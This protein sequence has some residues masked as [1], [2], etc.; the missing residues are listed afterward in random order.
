MSL[1]DGFKI[2]LNPAFLIEKAFTLWGGGGGGGGD[3][4]QTS[5]STNLPEYAKPYYQELLKQT[6]KAVFQ[7]DAAGN[8]TGVKPYTPYTGER[9]AGFTPEQQAIQQQV[10][11][12]GTPEGFA[13]GQG[14]M[15]DVSSMAT[16]AGLSGLQRALSYQPGQYNVGA[17]TAPTAAGGTMEAARSTYAPNLTTFQMAGPESVSA[18]RAAAEM[19]TPGAAEYYMSPFQ[20]A[21]TDIQKREALRQANVE[22]QAAAMGAI[23]RGTFGGARQALLQSEKDRGTAQL[24]SDIQAKG[25]QSAFENAQKQFEADQQRRMAAQQLNVQS[26]LQAELAN[27]QMRYNT[28]QQNLSAALSVQNLGTETGRA[29]ALANLNNEQQANV[30]NLAAKLQTQGLNTEQ[31]MRASL[32]NQQTQL[33][34]S[35]LMEQANQFAA[36]TGKDIGIAGMNQALE[37]GKAQVAAAAQEQASNLE[38]LKAQAATAEE[39]QQLD[40]QI[41]DLK[42]NTF[43]EQQNF[44]RSMLEYYS[45]I[46]RGNAG[47]LGTTQVNYAQPP[48]MLSQVGGLGLAGLGLYN[49]LGKQG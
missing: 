19:F 38:R 35:Q 13:A 49:V 9:V 33:Q 42:Y 45:N 1:L 14:D 25:S 36:A 34:L 22:K 17:V 11:G 31:A 28:A 39:K 24:L 23:G 8:V 16:G 44:Q 5:Y 21:V 48:S 46:L 2:F 29:M 4:K 40:Q 43:M 3:T 6:G 37:A 10:F 47:A 27:Q 26:G 20:Q 12:M 41:K 32:A 15:Q 7:T 18:E 30:Q